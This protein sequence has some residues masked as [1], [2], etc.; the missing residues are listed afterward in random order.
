[1]SEGATA[2]LQG[3]ELYA[4]S[5]A[6]GFKGNPSF[7]N[8]PYQKNAKPKSPKFQNIKFFSISA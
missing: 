6:G 4:G 5:Q 8:R 3:W 1:V 2:E 7:W